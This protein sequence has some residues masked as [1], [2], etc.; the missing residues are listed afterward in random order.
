LKYLCE[1]NQDCIFRGI[2]I[3]DTIVQ[4]S[5]KVDVDQ[6]FKIDRIQQVV[7]LDWSTSD[8]KPINEFNFQGL[9]S[10]TSP[11]LFPYGVADPTKKDRTIAVSE[12]DGFSHLL[13]YA[14]KNTK[15]N[16]LYYPFVQ[17]PRFKFWAYDRLRRHK[18]LNQSSI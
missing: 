18:A 10:M 7:R 12:T 5:V 15:T 16:E 13:K 17:H 11:S 6:P 8:T 1:N 3:N 2:V 4:K 9:C 14:T